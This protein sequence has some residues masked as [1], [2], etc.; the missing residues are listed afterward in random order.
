MNT[1]VLP[2]M[3]L[4]RPALFGSLNRRHPL[5]W[6]TALAFAALMLVCAIFSLFDERT[7]NGVS[8]WSKP[9][10]FSLSIAVYFA[11][12]AWFAPLLPNAYLEARKGRWLTLIPIVC[13]VFEIVYIVVQASRGE[14]SHFNFTTPFYSAMY[15]LMGTGAVAMVSVCLWMGIVILRHHGVHS[16]YAFAVGVGLV[17]TFLLGGGFGGYLGGHMSHWVGGTQSDANGIWLLKWSR[18]GGDLRVAHFFGMHAMQLL[19]MLAALLPGA[20]PRRVAIGV[21]IGMAGVY[22]AGTTFTFVQALN[23]TPFI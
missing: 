6:R 8:V 23:G 14:A 16:P 11:T 19:P 7:L 22:A 9:F 18:D 20:L 5:W 21:V 4:R 12:L 2:G 1:W 3:V 10:K 15:S 17:L 13:A